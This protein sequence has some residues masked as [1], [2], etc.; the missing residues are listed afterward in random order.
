LPSR[1]SEPPPPGAAPTGRPG[2]G[3]R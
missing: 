1:P 3:S 2:R